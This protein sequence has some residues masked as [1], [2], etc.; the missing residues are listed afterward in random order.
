MGSGKF[1]NATGQ[2]F[3]VSCHTF[4]RNNYDDVNRFAFSRVGCSPSHHCYALC[5]M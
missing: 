3:F 4:T 5:R 1:V 2:V